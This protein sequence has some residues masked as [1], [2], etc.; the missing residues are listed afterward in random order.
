LGLVQEKVTAILA[1]VAADKGIV[2]DCDALNTG[3][4]LDS[5]YSIDWSLVQELISMITVLIKRSF[6]SN[7]FIKLI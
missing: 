7:I 5:K 6:D 3:V 1:L 4:L 2:P